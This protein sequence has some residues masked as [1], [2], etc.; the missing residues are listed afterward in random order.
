MQSQFLT[1]AARERRDSQSQRF[2]QCNLA[3]FRC[4]ITFRQEMCKYTN[5][6]YFKVDMR[7][8]DAKRV[9]TK[10]NSTFRV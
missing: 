7:P 1:A 9:K 10:F 6:V 4:S 3:F 8:K 2:Q 5:D